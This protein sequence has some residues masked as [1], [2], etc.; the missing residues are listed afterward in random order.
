MAGGHYIALS[1]MRTRL[2]QLYRLADEIANA[3]TAGY[4][5]ERVSD[6]EARRPAFDAALESAIDVSPGGRRLDVRSGNV[7]D[8]GRD[9]DVA[10][11]G[12]GYLS[13]Q[14][15]AG[16]RYTR[17]GHFTRQTDG[18]LTTTDGAV[19][20]GTDGPLT[21]GP[22]EVHFDADGTVRTG[23]TIA[24]HLAIVEFDHPEQLVREG[25]ALLKADGVSA[26][27]TTAATVHGGSL[28]ESNVSVVE[29]IAELTHVSRSF[30]ALQKAVSV[31][32]NDVDGRSIDLLGR[33]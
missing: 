20:M 29:R 11:G 19:V 2:F 23:K 13:V 3:N 7:I 21:L 24:G 17:N 14:T 6:S 8:T 9:L 5:G 26:T 32:M 31:M 16:T 25:G 18:T 12:T 28:E 15:Q 10:I 1:G 27:P 30:E 22:G 33:R 4:K